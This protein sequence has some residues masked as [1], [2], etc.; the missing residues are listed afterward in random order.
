MRE[1]IFAIEISKISRELVF[2][3]TYFREFR[4]LAIFSTFREN[5]LGYFA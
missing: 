3:V 1:L 4:D 5:Y 2:A